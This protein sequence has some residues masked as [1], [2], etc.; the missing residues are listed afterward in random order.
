MI[1]VRVAVPA[2]QRRLYG[3]GDKRRYRR[4]YRVPRLPRDGVPPLRHVRLPLCG[5]GALV[6]VVPP[7]P[8]RQVPRPRVVN[9]LRKR[10]R[11]L[12]SHRQRV[13][14]PPLRRLCSDDLPHDPTEPPPL[15]PAN[16]P[17]LR[18]KHALRHTQLSALTKQARA[19]LPALHR[20]LVGA[21]LGD[22]HDV[23]DI[24]G[25]AHL[26]QQQRQLLHVQRATLLHV[27]D[28]EHAAQ[29]GVAGVLAALL[30]RLAPLLLGPLPLARVPGCGLCS[31]LCGLCS[32]L[33]TQRGAG[34]VDSAVAAIGTG[35]RA[36]K[37]QQRRQSPAPSR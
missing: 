12:Q 32:F 18:L 31:S 23:G 16:V 21:G 33:R 24:Y 6:G 5:N 34:R 27:E 22:V 9:E 28:V 30:R 4:R 37:A 26:G 11:A 19:R 3:M 1:R 2:L 35:S 15:L 20:L 25:D 10:R 29:D 8:P 17:P 7:R 36:A 14:G 13:C